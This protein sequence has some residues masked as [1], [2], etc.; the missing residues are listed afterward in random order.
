MILF[1][2]MWFVM[3]VICWKCSICLH[4]DN[5]S[6]VIF[7]NPNGHCADYPIDDLHGCDLNVCSSFDSDSDS[8]SCPADW[9]KFANVNDG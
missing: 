3:N 6:F 7:C 4:L 5:C 9:L 8:D 2:W 1:E